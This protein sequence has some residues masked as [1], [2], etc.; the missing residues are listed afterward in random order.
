MATTVVVAA[1]NDDDEEEEEE[2]EEKEEK[3]EDLINC[4]MANRRHAIIWTKDWL[5]FWLIYKSAGV[6]GIFY[7]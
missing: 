1:A 2:E 3:E 4:L 7:L 6:A 5:F